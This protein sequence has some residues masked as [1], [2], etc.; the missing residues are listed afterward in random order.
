MASMARSAPL[1]LCAALFLTACARSTG[2][3]S[4]PSASV[5]AP[6]AAPDGAEPHLALARIAYTRDLDWATAAREIDLALRLRPDFAAARRLRAEYLAS[7]GRFPAALEEAHQA[8]EVDPSGATDLT[9]ARIYYDLHRLPEALDAG[10]RSLGKTDSY[11]GHLHVGFIL[12]AQAQHGA[13]LRELEI[14]HDRGRDGGSALAIAYG[15][16]VAGDKHRAREL[17]A[18]LEEQGA[19]GSAFPYRAAAV[20]LALGE[21]DR[22]L[23]LLQRALAEKDPWMNQLQVDPVMDA[24]HT[25]PRFVEMVRQLGLLSAP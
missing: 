1:A 16:A 14:A 2:S 9:F 4:A 15:Y 12:L 10:R 17:L 20:H 19:S 13:A 11:S 25:D 24:L 22:A 7:M 6:P 8:E 21:K 18:S 5:V 23:E 3:P